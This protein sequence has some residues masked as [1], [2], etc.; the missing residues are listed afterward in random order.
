[1]EVT[2]LALSRRWYFDSNEELLLT[3]FSPSDCFALSTPAP[4]FFAAV[5]HPRREL[6]LSM[7]FPSQIR[8]RS[9][10]LCF[11]PD[12]VPSQQSVSSQISE[13]LSFP[14]ESDPSHN[15]VSIQ[16]FLCLFTSLVARSY[17]GVCH[18]DPEPPIG[19][20]CGERSCGSEAFQA[21]PLGH[22]HRSPR[23]GPLSAV[24]V[25]QNFN[26]RGRFRVVSSSSYALASNAG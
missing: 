22:P 3:T 1:M 21:E 11:T 25:Q 7:E 10:S 2:L 26:S 8:V 6:Y 23:L 19:L 20:R 24:R 16:D 15:S 18:L 17:C 4:P 9:E 13:S 14:S 12:S 5:L